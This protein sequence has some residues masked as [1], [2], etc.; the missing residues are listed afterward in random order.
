MPTTVPP[1]MNTPIDFTG[2]NV[3]VTGSSRG[4]GEATI[5]AFASRG[6]ACIVNYVDDPSGRNQADSQRVAD[7]IKAAATIQCNVADAQQVLAM[8][9]QIRDRFGGLDILVNNAGIM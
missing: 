2:K 8:M 7:E 3:L 5:R 6:A 1:A 9:T 4:I